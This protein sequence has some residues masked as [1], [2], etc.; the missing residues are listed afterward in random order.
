VPVARML[1]KW[2]AVMRYAPFP[3][4][5]LVQSNAGKLRRQSHKVVGISMEKPPPMTGRHGAS[6]FPHSNEGCKLTNCGLPRTPPARWPAVA[7]FKYGSRTDIQ[8]NWVNG[9]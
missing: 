8:R 9:V 3:T 1:W 2:T 4:I 7:Y 5:N 6:E